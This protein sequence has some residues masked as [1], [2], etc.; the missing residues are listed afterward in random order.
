MN[1][2]LYDLDNVKKHCDDLSKLITELKNYYNPTS[3]ERK[4]F[5]SR[6]DYRESLQQKNEIPQDFY[7]FRCFDSFIQIVFNKQTK[8]YQLYV[9]GF[10]T[11]TLNAY[12]R[13]QRSEKSFIISQDFDV[14]LRLFKKICNE[15][16]DNKVQQ[17]ELFETD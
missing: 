8:F 14:T 6:S 2:T 1:L 7:F 3:Y 12:E 4:L 17:N 9:D 10:Y 16:I 11:T 5:V 15:I 13:V